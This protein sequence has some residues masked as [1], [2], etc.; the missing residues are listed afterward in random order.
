M[1]TMMM[2]K[3][4]MMMVMKAGDI[5]EDNLGTTDETCLDGLYANKVVKRTL[6]LDIRGS[7]LSLAR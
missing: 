7:N 1:T 6:R 4:V 3:L 2:T 5:D